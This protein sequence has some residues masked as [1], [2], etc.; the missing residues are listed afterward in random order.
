MISLGAF[1]GLPLIY[2][3]VCVIYARI[4]LMASLGLDNQRYFATHK[5]EW[6]GWLKVNVLYAPFWSVRHNREL[7][8]SRAID[9]GTLPTRFE[10]FFLVGYVVGNIVFCTYLV[11]WSDETAIMLAEIRNRTG[12]LAVVNMVPLFLLAGR[13]NPLIQLM[14]VSFDTYNL[15][16]R[17][18]GRIVVVQATTHSACWIAAKVMA[19]EF[20][21]TRSLCVILIILSRLG[22]RGRL[23]SK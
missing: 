11:E 19:G 1:A 16:H 14:G 21:R 22:A 23:Y 6:V 7:Q 3:L 18:L 15:I 10:S 20:Y 17:W 12:I 9:I 4:R 2:R 8:L 5:H 13:N